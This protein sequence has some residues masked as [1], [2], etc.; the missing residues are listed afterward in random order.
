MRLN[1]FAA[2]SLFSIL[3][4]A[5]QAGSDGATSITYSSIDTSLSAGGTTIK[6][7][8]NA[9]STGLSYISPENNI[10]TMLAY[11]TQ[12]GTIGTATYL[13]STFTLGVGYEV[14]DTSTGADTLG[15]SVVLGVGYSSTTGDATVAGTEYDLKNDGTLLYAQINGDVTESMRV[16]G[17]FTSDTGGDSDPT[18]G[19]GMAFDVSGNNAVS[20]GYSSNKTTTNGVTSEVTGWSL[21]WASTF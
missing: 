18:F 3:G 5:A 19:I 12:S 15:T 14:I 13:M 4:G 11:T 6:G 7:D 2:L 8:G 21:G 16:F 1:Y 10:G 17:S 20:I 9:F